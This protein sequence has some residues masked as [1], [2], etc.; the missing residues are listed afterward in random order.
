[1]WQVYLF[2]ANERQAIE[3]RDDVKR[4]VEGGSRLRR[5]RTA[6][7]DAGVQRVTTQGR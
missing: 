2:L 1:M 4:R 7:R 6:R 3:H 5:W